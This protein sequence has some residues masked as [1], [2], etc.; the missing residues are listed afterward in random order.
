M[1]ERAVKPY[2][3]AW[4]AA[5]MIGSVATLPAVWAFADIANGLMA[6]PN[7]V[8]L[9][10]LSGVAAAETRKYLWEGDID[11]PADASAA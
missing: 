1:G 11:R 2:R 9:I 8:S 3:L 6:V 5:V 7:L 10:A 4:V